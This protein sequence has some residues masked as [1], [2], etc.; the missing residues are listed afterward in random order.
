MLRF[1]EPMDE[2]IQENRRESIRFELIV[3]L[4]AELSLCRIKDRELRSRTQRI[5]LNNISPG[6]CQFKTHLQIPPRDDVEW[7]LKFQMGKYAAKFRVIILNAGHE[8]G[9]QVYGC[10][11][12]MTGLER[13]SFQYRL[14][15]YLHAV[16]VS[17]PHIHTIYKK[18]ADRDNDGHFRKLDVT[19]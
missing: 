7:L 16:L 12:A 6:G 3:P 4:F 11:W 19:S 18:I 5:L 15:E 8:E 13:Q 14:N 17:S 1:G 10:R 9:L 2:E